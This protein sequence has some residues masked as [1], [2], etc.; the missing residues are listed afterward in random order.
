MVLNM[1]LWLT[2]HAAWTAAK[3]EV[4]EGEA[5]R[6]HTCL[7]R[8]AGMFEFVLQNTGPFVSWN[9]GPQKGCIRSLQY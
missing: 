8:A 9:R 3:D 5:K 1:A 2:K 7:R 6:V 4:R